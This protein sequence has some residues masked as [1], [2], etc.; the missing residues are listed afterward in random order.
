MST[1]DFDNFLGF[2]RSYKAHQDTPDHER[3]LGQKE[4]LELDLTMFLGQPIERVGNV[5]LVGLSRSY[6]FNLVDHSND[7]ILH[8]PDLEVVSLFTYTLKKENRAA[9]EEIQRFYEE[10]G[11]QTHTH[12]ELIRNREKIRP[13]SKRF[14][15]P[16]EMVQPAELQRIAQEKLG[17][18]PEGLCF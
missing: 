14:F 4:G 12:R 13:E 5:R 7:P 3:L 17:Y 15:N 18:D 2:H 10:H 1:E 9:A 11:W 8:L 6:L 16:V